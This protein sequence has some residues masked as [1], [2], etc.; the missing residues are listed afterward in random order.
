MSGPHRRA[1]EPK[2]IKIKSDRS[3]AHIYA[4][5]QRVCKKCGSEFIFKA[6]DQVHLASVGSFCSTACNTANLKDE[7]AK[8]FARLRLR[9]QMRKEGYL[10]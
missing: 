7:Q 10:L 6:S 8:Y 3:P 5:E 9:K 4:D 1:E 2:P